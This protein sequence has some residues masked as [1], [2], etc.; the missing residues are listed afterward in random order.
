MKTYSTKLTEVKRERHVIDATGQTLGR[1]ASRIT[2]LLMGK[3]K[4]IYAPNLDTGDFVVVVNAAK[5]AY[6]GAKKGT[7]KQY[8][9]HTGFLG[10]LRNM[11]LDEMMEKHPTRAVE[12]AIKGML[13]HTRL[14]ARLIKKL[15]V[16]EGDV[17]KP[18]VKAPKAQKVKTETGEAPQAGT[19]PEETKS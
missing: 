7:L 9:W 15:E 11:S 4:P 14:G 1:L 10:H 16:Y 13:P 2:P 8:I 5:I 12:F 19:K 6:T 17:P 18:K 3:N